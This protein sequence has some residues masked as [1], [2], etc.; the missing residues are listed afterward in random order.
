MIRIPEHN[1]RT[2]YV[3]RIERV[4]R[5]VTDN[6]DKCGYSVSGI[7]DHFEIL[8]VFFVKMPRKFFFLS[9]A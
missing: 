9:T 3:H 8:V 2:L 1:G 5:A 4:V 6:I 7:V